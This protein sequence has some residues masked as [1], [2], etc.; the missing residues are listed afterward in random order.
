[1]RE[2][3]EE[4]RKSTH[5]SRLISLLIYR[6]FFV[7]RCKVSDGKGST[8]VSFGRS[9]DP[10]FKKL[11]QADVNYLVKRKALS[12]HKVEDISPLHASHLEMGMALFIARFNATVAMSGVSRDGAG[13]WRGEEGE[14]RKREG[15]GSLGG[16]TVVVSPQ[17]VGQESLSS[18]DLFS[19]LSQL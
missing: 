5:D 16:G 4:E 6:Q 3:E 14:R 10:V 2:Q 19:L 7:V 15:G 11:T 9:G 12:V 8:K 13:G 18:P 17:P 1:M